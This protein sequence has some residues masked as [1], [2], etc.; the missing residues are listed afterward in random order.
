MLLQ[1]AVQD[2]GQLPYLYA[3][4]GRSRALSLFTCR[5][6]LYGA[7]N[8]YCCRPPGVH[9]EEVDE[10][11]GF[12]GE[13]AELYQ[14]YRRGY[15]SAVFDALTGAFGLASDD[16]VIDLGCGTGQLTLP[17]ASRVQAVAGVD[18][19]P[20][21]LARARRAAAEQGVTN[22]SW[23][24]GADTD[25]PALAALL[26]GSRAGAVTV[27][28]AMHWMRYRELIPALV[29]LL[30]PGGGVAVI[31]NGT[32]MWL[33]DSA[34]SRALRGFLEQWSGSRPANPCGTD[35][36]SRQRYRD[37]MTETGLDVTEARYDYTDDLDLDHLI[38]GVYSAL[39]VHKLPPPGQR[40]AFA[41][42]VRSA[43]A[44]HAPFTELVCVRMLFGRRPLAWVMDLENSVTLAV[45]F[46]ADQGTDHAAD[47]ARLCD[48]MEEAAQAGRYPRLTVERP[49]SV[50]NSLL[51]GEFAAPRAIRWYLE[52]ELGRLAAAGARISV[53]SGREAV[54]L[55]DP[56]FG[57]AV[58]ETQWDL[59]R[60][61]L[62]LFPPERMAL[63]I[64]RL[65]H[66]TGTSA[67]LF[68]RYVLFTNYDWHV[69]EFRAA[70]P[71]CV[72]PDRP[73]RQMPAWHHVLPGNT[74]VS[75]VNIGV[76]PSNAKT[77][78]DHLAVLR[79][80]MV[81]MIGHCA[82]LRNHQDIGDLVLASAYMRDDRVL[83]DLLPLS[84]PVVSNHT[85]NSLL[86]DELT[87]RDLRS[88][89]GIVFTTANRNWE[90][91]L[92]VVQDQLR[93]SRALA[94]DMESATVAA[95]GFRYRIPTATLLAVSDKPLHA[96]P[97]SAADA[98]QFY[99]ASR[100]Q[101][102]DIAISVTRKVSQLY[103]GGLPSAGLASPDEPLLGL[104]HSGD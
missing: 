60:K 7:P 3:S 100:R 87:A 50:H 72:G 9:A 74:G 47:I 1:L 49:W 63:S 31:S 28:Q 21:M 30:R 17:V 88:R 58:D 78:T 89:M 25:L 56:R 73:G 99:T 75:M 83:D 11:L 29:P 102:V 98:Q 26:G 79:P 27:G 44:P 38:G 104:G 12:G 61:K 85:L 55:R 42:Q 62:F 77:I 46:P 54:G 53:S 10:D 65:E 96:R 92:A 97:K 95:N 14:R 59:R 32:P 51:Q 82:G 43:V 4:S 22:V 103:P 68:Q 101:H 2:I 41:D 57:P 39:P 13:V 81:L 91:H 52:R 86:L 15:P 24:L 16:I 76:G 93:A 5:R 34:W 19:E 8:L 18:P 45:D 37:T 94:V 71:D 23:V 69:E 84:V 35:D 67:E 33:Q 36:A 90:L 64:D 20:D 80:D 66:Y 70:L 6:L 48:A 40:A